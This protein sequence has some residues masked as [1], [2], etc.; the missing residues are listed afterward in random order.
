MCIRDR[1]VT[2]VRGR[3]MRIARADGKNMPVNMD[4][5]IIYEPALE[6][7]LGERQLLFA[8]PKGAAWR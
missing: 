5:E 2:W 8:A 1:Y 6:I 4:G 3:E 7:S